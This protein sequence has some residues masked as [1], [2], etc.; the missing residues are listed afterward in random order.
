M[1]ITKTDP[2]P[3]AAKLAVEPNGRIEGWRERSPLE[4][5]QYSAVYKRGAYTVEKGWGEGVPA[6]GPGFGL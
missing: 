3:E 5:G 6:S 1:E 2:D 4:V